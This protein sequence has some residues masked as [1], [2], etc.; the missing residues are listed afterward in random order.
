[1]RCFVMPVT[2]LA[3]LLVTQHYAFAETITVQAVQPEQVVQS[4]QQVSY[5]LAGL[6]REEAKQQLQHRQQLLQSPSLTLNSVWAHQLKVIRINNLQYTTAV[7]GNDKLS[8]NW[9]A[10]FHETLM[11]HQAVIWLVKDDA[12]QSGLVTIH[13]LFPSLT[14]MRQSAELLADYY[15]IHHY[16]VLL[17]AKR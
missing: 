13:S 15:G 2:G 4:L 17:E 1:M 9:L 14:V 3:S 10:H 8:L 6:T 11:T 16:P 7:V 12:Q 5:S